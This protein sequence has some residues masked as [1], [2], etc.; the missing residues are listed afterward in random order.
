MTE[1]PAATDESATCQD[2]LAEKLNS[3]REATSI[4]LARPVEE[5]PLNMPISKHEPADK[6]GLVATAFFGLGV[7]FLLPW[8]AF[9]TAIDYFEMLYPGAHA[10][11]VFSVCYMLP[12]LLALSVMLQYSPQAVSVPTRIYGGYT[13]FLLSMLV[14]PAV[15]AWKLEDQQ[16]GSGLLATSAAVAV[17]GMS[18]GLVQGTLFGLA[19]QMPPKYAQ[20]CISG[21]ACAGL[22]TSLLRILSKVAVPDTNSGLRTSANI[23]F[24]VAAVG[25]FACLAGFWW[26][27]RSPVYAFFINHKGGRSFKPSSDVRLPDSAVAAS[28]TQPDNGR[29]DRVPML[30]E[31]RMDG[32]EGS[33]PYASMAPGKVGLRVPN[34]KLV[35][36]KIWPNAVSIAGVCIVTLSIFP[37][38]LAED[39]KSDTLGDWYPILLITT[40]NLADLLGKSTPPGDRF[41]L[42]GAGNAHLLM[43]CVASRFLFIPLFALCTMGPK[44]LRS[45]L[46]VVTL[47]LA[48][49]LSSG[50]LT[51]VCMV[52]AP[53][54][55]NAHEEQLTGNLMVFFLIFGL[56]TGALCGWLWLL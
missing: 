12:N 7:G 42:D 48:L 21:T 49:G 44:V 11:R 28:S 2:K 9:I 25:V 51:T 33:V 27:Q 43:G 5:L 46:V 3:G 47:T 6:Y 10:D 36:A 50:W 38:F 55:V 15:E 1:Q 8:N 4:D 20:A 26:L 19:S 17:L 18:D 13:L 31:S 14:V 54:R 40:Y 41:M 52:T 39:V 16:L 53:T 30:D 32:T 37:G 34:A 22:I 23:Y 24:T 35:L 29:C 45:E 56:T